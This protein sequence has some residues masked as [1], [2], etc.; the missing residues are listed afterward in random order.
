V[1]TSPHLAQQLHEHTLAVGDTVLLVLGLGALSVLALTGAIAC[2]IAWLA[3]R[4]SSPQ[5][6]PAVL[7]GLAEVLRAL[8]AVLH[9]SKR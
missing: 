6:R 2:V 4:G 8:A 9:R 5:Q 7:R 3:L 1:P